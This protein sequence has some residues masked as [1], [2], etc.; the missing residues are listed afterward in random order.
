MI[1]FHN[2]VYIFAGN[3]MRLNLNM[4]K[5]LPRRQGGHQFFHK[6]SPLTELGLH[7]AYLTGQYI[8]H[9]QSY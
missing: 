4:P 1:I 9:E 8:Y 3:Y 6:D 2:V 5:K 7:E